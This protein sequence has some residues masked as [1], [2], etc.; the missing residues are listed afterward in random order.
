MSKKI[1]IIGSGVAG[2]T[3]ATNLIDQGFNPKD[4]TLIDKGQDAW[5]RP[6]HEVMLGVKWWRSVIW[7]DFYI[8]IIKNEM[9]NI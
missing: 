9:R 2:I 8:F 5:D 1:V 6:E 4:I 7:W 3:A